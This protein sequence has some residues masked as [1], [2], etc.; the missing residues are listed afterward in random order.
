MN[1]AQPGNRRRVRSA[2]WQPP[3]ALCYA[4]SAGVLACET[5]GGGNFSV[6]LGAL[7]SLATAEGYAAQPGE[8]ASSPATRSA[9][10]IFATSSEIKNTTSCTTDAGETP[11]FQANAVFT[12]PLVR[13]RLACVLCFAER[14]RRWPGIRCGGDYDEK[15]PLPAQPTQARRREGYAA[16]A[17]RAGD[18][19]CETLGVGNFFGYFG[20]AALA[21]RAGDLACETLG[22]GNFLRQVRR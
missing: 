1:A 14:L 3:K 19:A 7:R 15:I 2:A 9:M 13:R 5:L 21:R 8:Q 11:A 18:L 4:K 16:L 20:Y 17:R 22:V 12:L 10:V 6:T